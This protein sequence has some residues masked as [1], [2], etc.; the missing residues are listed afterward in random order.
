MPLI[1]GTQ[2]EK[3]VMLSFSYE[4][5]ARNRYTFYSIHARKQGFMEVAE[6][7][8]LTANQERMHGEQF[9]ELLD[10]GLLEI[11]GDKFIAGIAGTTTQNLVYAA[12]QEEMEYSIIYP[13]FAEVAEKENFPGI[14]ELYKEICNAEQAHKKRFDYYLK[15]FQDRSV[16]ECKEDVLWQ[17]QKC[18]YTHQGRFAPDICP[19]CRHPQGYFYVVDSNI[20]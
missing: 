3:N 13:Q 11:T 6:I 1:K 12:E 8:E 17:C 16:F 4:S 10:G 18:G 15:Y 7:F 9:Y 20:D 2:T 5:N 19:L 14:A